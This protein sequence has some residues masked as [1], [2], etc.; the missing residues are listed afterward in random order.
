MEESFQEDYKDGVLGDQ[1]AHLVNSKRKCASSEDASPRPTRK[2]KQEPEIGPPWTPIGPVKPE[3]HD[4][5]MTDESDLELEAMEAS[6][7]N[8]S[9]CSLFIFPSCRNV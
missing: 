9:P 7:S 4:S 3:D 8:S 2:P 6:D 1:S 5:I